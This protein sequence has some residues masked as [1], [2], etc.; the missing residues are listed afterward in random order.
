MI[1]KNSLIRSGIDNIQALS[2]IKEMCN[3]AACDDVDIIIFAI[4]G[5]IGLLSTFSLYVLLKKLL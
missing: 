4:I 5:I 1:L 2:S 3:L